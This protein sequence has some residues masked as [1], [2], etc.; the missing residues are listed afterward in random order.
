MPRAKRRIIDT[1]DAII[2]RKG[3]QSLHALNTVDKINMA[4][5]YVQIMCMNIELKQTKNP[6]FCSTRECY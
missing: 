6:F 2:K 3:N 1:K 4:S 5:L